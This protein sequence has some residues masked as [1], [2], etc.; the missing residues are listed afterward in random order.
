MQK[1]APNTQCAFV[2][3]HADTWDVVAMRLD[4]SRE[5]GIFWN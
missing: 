2:M 4:A 5:I 3:K 1:G